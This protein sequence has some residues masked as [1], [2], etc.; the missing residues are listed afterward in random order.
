MSIFKDMI[1]NYIRSKPDGYVYTSGNIVHD[2]NL[3]TDAKDHDHD[4][5][6]HCSDVFQRQLLEKAGIRIELVGGAKSPKY[7]RGGRRPANLYKVKRTSN[8]KG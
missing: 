6:W 1:M 2:L 4:I 3:E 8:A 7:S 5:F